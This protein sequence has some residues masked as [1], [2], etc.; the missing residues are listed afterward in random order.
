VYRLVRSVLFR[1]D[2]ERSHRIAL[3]TLRWL[4]A[5]P[6]VPLLLR[7]VYGVANPALKTHVMGIEFPNPV[8]LAA[9]LDK[10]ADSVRA[11]FALGFGGIEL[12]TVTPEPQPGN[13]PK[14]LFRV[15][16]HHAL[17][18]RLGFPSV[19]I[20]AFLENLRRSGKPGPI[21]INVGKNRSTANENAVTDYVRSLRAVYAIADYV[22]INVSSP[23]TPQL[24]ALQNRE[25]L[26]ALLLALKNEQVE[27]GKTRSVFVPLAVKISPDLND[28]Q[29]NDIADLILEHKLD[30]VIATNST[31]ERPGMEG[32]LLAAEAG[33]L[34]G[35]PLKDRSTEVIRLLYR[36]LRGQVPI[37]GVGGI[38][39]ADD[40]W[41]KMVAGAD[42]IQ[43]YTGFIYQGP[44]LVRRICRGLLRRTRAAGCNTLEEAV[45]HARSGVRMM[46]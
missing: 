31:V 20:D 5:I 28:E 12:G 17:I 35:R 37:V 19:G 38:E 42:L 25:N 36:R 29:I 2:A 34:S 21:G 40:A 26:G 43:V 4:C 13:P 44:A 23:N 3:R 32:E 39:S 16:R 27:L 18:N 22:V 6:G 11:L 15:T 9:G 24:R 33:G 14:R 30:A 10:N 7:L 45:A 8:C 1:F 41:E 46:R